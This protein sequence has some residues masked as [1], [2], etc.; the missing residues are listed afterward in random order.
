MN[1][2]TC[3]K[4]GHVATYE[5]GAPQACPACGAIYAKVEEALRAAAEGRASAARV[6]SAPNAPAALGLRAAPA[7]EA[8]D[9]PDVHAFAARMRRESLY[10]AWR[11]IVGIFTLLGYGM[12][13]IVLIGGVVAAFQG[14]VAAGVIGMSVSLFLAIA[15][16]VSREL[17]LML[18]DLS[19][20]SVRMAA[21]R[22]AG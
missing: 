3:K 13:A 10:P 7:A 16:K 14:S 1:N 5:G 4:C 2:K 12:A 9:P 19:D 11:N 17:S 6:A 8:S 20:A 21:Q 22:E 15:A 18:A